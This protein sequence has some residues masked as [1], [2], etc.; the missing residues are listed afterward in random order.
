MSLSFSSETRLR[1][2]GVKEVAPFMEGD[3]S[4]LTLFLVD[5]YGP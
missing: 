3:S 4:S 1:L 2:N 5:P